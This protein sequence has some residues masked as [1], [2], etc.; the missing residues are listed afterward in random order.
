[1]KKFCPVSFFLFTILIKNLLPQTYVPCKVLEITSS[2]TLNNSIA[3]KVD[4]LKVKIL[5][6]NFKNKIAFINNFIYNEKYKYYTIKVKK[7][8]IIIAKINTNFN[9]NL[10]GYVVHYY[11]IKKLLLILILFFILSF[12]TIN[13]KA[14]KAILAL[15]IVFIIIIFYIYLL[16]NGFAPFLASFLASILASFVTFLIVL[17][18]KIKL[19]TTTL[20]ITFSF[21][22]ITILT[23]IVFKIASI[24]GLNTSEG[25]MLIFFSQNI[26]NFNITN[27]KEFFI[28]SILIFSSGALMDI[29][30]AM[31]SS[32]NEILKS[33]PKINFF[34]LIK[35]GFSIGKDIIATMTNTLIFVTISNSVLILLIFYIMK[36]PFHR[37]SN[38]EFFILTLLPGLIGSCGMV[39]SVP[40]AIFIFAFINNFKSKIPKLNK[41]FTPIFSFI[42]IFL[43]NN[44]LSAFV[45]I[46]EEDLECN[47]ITKIYL[48]KNTEIYEIAQI[49]KI[50][51]KNQ[52]HNFNIEAKIL[53]GNFK[54]QVVKFDYYS[55]NKNNLS[56]KKSDKFV[57]WIKKDNNKILNAY[58]ADKYRFS[59]IYFLIILF[60]I[61]L[62]LIGK[63][64]GIKI[65]VSII[66]SSFLIAFPFVQLVSKGLNI[67]FL[68]FVLS[69]L[70]IILINLAIYKNK[71][72]FK[73]TIISSFLSAVLSY[74]FIF[75]LSKFLKINGSSLEYM[76]QVNYFNNN[77]NSGLIK[78]LPDII[79]S[80]I[81]FSA[82]GAII[83]MSITIASALN[84]IFILNPESN[85]K[86]LIKH[87]I[88]IGG[89]VFSTMINTLVLAYIGSNLPF[90]F[91]N[92]I[93]N[94]SYVNLLNSEIISIEIA[95]SV[96]STLAMLLTVPI[97]SF[98][99][100]YLLVKNKKNHYL[101]IREIT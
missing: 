63:I 24:T 73:S 69:F 72:M 23:S 11:R 10:S 91:S 79:C 64:L 98:T 57:I 78:N 83:D 38:F 48:Y 12:L 81:V 89:D 6:G 92:I 84:E 46:P 40:V 85:F 82:I 33:N 70:I 30:T 22:F 58:I 62:F 96:S 18:G 1:M 7:N 99:V 3:Q 86:T 13:T 100:S 50:I 67:T 90:L 16:K 95:Q 42:L 2:K 56:L 15:I 25:R 55:E 93:G 97:T 71:I 43:L 21:I 45:S 94:L 26:K 52:T 17:K 60:F 29:S 75:S 76:Q 66:L 32:L 34:E 37:F 88:E 51:P 19:L 80:V 65:F 101:P 39:V 68:T 35:S 44:S 77:F 74:I 14:L 47:P 49:I 53:T 41:I 28:G 87:G 27:I 31:T 8:D 54:N 4:T 9:Q 20:T 36:T 5:K 59:V 61:L